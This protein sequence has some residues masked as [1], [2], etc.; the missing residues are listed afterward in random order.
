[1]NRKPF[2]KKKKLHHKFIFNDVFTRNQNVS[3]YWKQER[4]QK[5]ERSYV[6][7]YRY[8]I[9]YS[10]LCY[11]VGNVSYHITTITRTYHACSFR[12]AMFV[13]RKFRIAEPIINLTLSCQNHIMLFFSSHSP[14]VFPKFNK[15]MIPNYKTNYVFCSLETCRPMNILFRSNYFFIDF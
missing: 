9:D 5:F 8:Y 2:L 3:I 10:Q 12:Q 14:I 11:I 4:Y 6:T 1:M 7:I 13:K 15:L